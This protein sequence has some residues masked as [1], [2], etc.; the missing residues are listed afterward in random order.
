MIA[1][2][3]APGATIMAMVC[4]D[5]DVLADF[6]VYPCCKNPVNNPMATAE[7]YVGLTDETALRLA[8]HHNLK[9]S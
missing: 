7:L 6:N 8:Q 5:I 4:K 3:A 1:D 2:P 9:Y